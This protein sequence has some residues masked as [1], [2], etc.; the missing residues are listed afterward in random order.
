MVDQVTCLVKREGGSV[1]LWVGDCATKWLTSTL[2]EWEASNLYVYTWLHHRAKCRTG[3]F[4][5]LSPCPRSSNARCGPTFALCGMCLEGN[6]RD[7]ELWRS[8]VPVLPWAGGAVNKGG[9]A[10]SFCQPPSYSQE[11]GKPKSRKHYSIVFWNWLNMCKLTVLMINTVINIGRTW[12][13][14]LQRLI[15]LNNYKSSSNHI[16]LYHMFKVCYPASLSRLP[17]GER[18]AL[19]TVFCRTV[20]DMNTK[21]LHKTTKY[22]ATF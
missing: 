5:T 1:Q 8:A 4:R 11:G 6:Q 19:R 12:I 9:E 7:L 15:F 3:L 17:Y 16:F 2:P 20:V 18:M 13:Q 14:P 21:Q 22:L 10:E